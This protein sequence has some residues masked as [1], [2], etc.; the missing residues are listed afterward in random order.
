M[1]GDDI[2]ELP[3]ESKV[4]DAYPVKSTQLL[5]RGACCCEA[6]GVTAHSEINPTPLISVPGVPPTVGKS[7]H[8]GQDA[9]NSKQMVL[10]NN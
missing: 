7:A 10:K 2:Y 8:P 4:A 9:I 5:L 3:K 1:L 6:V